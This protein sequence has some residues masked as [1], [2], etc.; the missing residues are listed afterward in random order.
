MA[1]DE[2]RAFE[3]LAFEKAMRAFLDTLSDALKERSLIALSDGYY[4]HYGML[5]D[6]ATGAVVPII[7][8]IEVGRPLDDEGVARYRKIVK[9]RTQ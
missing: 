6:S 2:D 1:S 4:S 7:A 9:N 8:E 5:T 3:A